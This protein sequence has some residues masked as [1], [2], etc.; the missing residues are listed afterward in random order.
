MV[1][2]MIMR[3]GV[4]SCITYFKI[5]KIFFRTEEDD[6]D[7]NGPNDDPDNDDPGNQPRRRE[8]NIINEVKEEQNRVNREEVVV[9]ENQN[10]KEEKEV[11]NL[12]ENVV[13]EE[14]EVINREENEVKENIEEL[15]TVEENQNNEREQEVLNLVVDEE[16]E[17]E[18]DKKRKPF[19]KTINK[20]RY[21]MYFLRNRV[22]G[23]AI[24]YIKEN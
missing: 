5:L 17:I 2:F 6:L 19:K 3:Y 20:K 7:G 15:D 22:E 11:L 21:Y 23:I 1:G 13:K 16:R 10:K 18:I 9:E 12:E 14:K 24:E 8:Q 4:D